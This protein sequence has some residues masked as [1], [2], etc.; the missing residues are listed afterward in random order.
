MGHTINNLCEGPQDAVT[1]IY[2]VSDNTFKYSIFD[3]MTYFCNQS[4]RLKDFGRESFL[5]SLVKCP[6]AV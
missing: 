5:L 4:N 2:I 3:S 1:Y 6:L